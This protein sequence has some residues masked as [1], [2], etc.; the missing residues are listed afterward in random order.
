MTAPTPTHLDV[1]EV[2]DLIIQISTSHYV[3]KKLQQLRDEYRPA[4]LKLYEKWYFDTWQAIHNIICHQECNDTLTTEMY[5]T[6]EFYAN[7]WLR[8]DITT[9]HD[10]AKKFITTYGTL[11][12]LRAAAVKRKSDAAVYCSSTHEATTQANP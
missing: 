8:G 10:N 4:V 12:S 1:E 2:V 7:E 9:I 11:T 5:S 6:L 3:F